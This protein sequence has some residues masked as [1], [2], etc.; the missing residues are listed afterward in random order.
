M[1]S[2]IQGSDHR[3]YYTK[4]EGDGLQTH[5]IYFGGNRQVSDDNGF[6]VYLWWDRHIAGSPF[7]TPHNDRDTDL[8]LKR[9]CQEKF[10]ETHTREEF[11]ELIGKSYL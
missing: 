11:I 7:K 10:E 5:H 4:R 8:Y 1:E 9:L 3:C 2:I 6:T